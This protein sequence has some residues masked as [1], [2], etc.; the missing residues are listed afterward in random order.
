MWKKYYQLYSTGSC[1]IFWNIKSSS[2]P[3]TL[4]QSRCWEIQGFFSGWRKLEDATNWKAAARILDPN[5]CQSSSN[6]HWLMKPILAKK[7]FV[8]QDSK[9]L[10]SGQNRVKLDNASANP[11]NTTSWFPSSYTFTTEVLV[12]TGS[13][14]WSL[15]FARFVLF[16]TDA[17]PTIHDSMLLL[18]LHIL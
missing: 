5:Q 3:Q 15:P 6:S 14:K 12:Y 8:S 4:F 1:R 7:S 2:L 17:T 11:T 10:K 13:W 18:G 16:K 9:T